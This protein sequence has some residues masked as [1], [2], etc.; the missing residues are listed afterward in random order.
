HPLPGY[1]GPLPTK[2]FRWRMVRKEH[3]GK[4][5]LHI[6]ELYNR[7]GK[8][9]HIGPSEVSIRNVDAVVPLMSTNGLPKGLGWSYLVDHL[10]EV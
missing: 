6:Q 3:H 8:I 7:Y 9:V 2:L 10:S 4:Q 5:H 1:P